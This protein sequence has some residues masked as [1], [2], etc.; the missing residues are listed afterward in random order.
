MAMLVADIV[1]LAMLVA[2]IVALAMLVADIVVSTA[3]RRFVRH[4]PTS[5]LAYYLISW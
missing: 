5:S 3:Y 4:I 1:A 2:D